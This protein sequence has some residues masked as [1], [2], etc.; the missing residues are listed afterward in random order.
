MYVFFLTVKLLLTVC[1]CSFKF[2]LN[3]HDFMFSVNILM[4]KVLQKWHPSETMGRELFAAASVLL[5]QGQSREA[6][7]VLTNAL[8]CCK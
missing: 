7:K 2:C 4:S 8:V 1:G 6:V 5:K 3:K